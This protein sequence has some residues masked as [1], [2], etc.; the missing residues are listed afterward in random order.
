M[1]EKFDFSVILNLDIQTG[2]KSD[3][4]NTNFPVFIVCFLCKNGQDLMAV[5]LCNTPGQ[6][7]ALPEES[8]SGHD[9]F[10]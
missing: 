3:P 10:I 1:Q 8:N 9:T 2:S 6:Y 5:H 7:K 4:K